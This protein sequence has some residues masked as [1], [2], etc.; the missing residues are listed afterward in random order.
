MS[1]ALHLAGGVGLFLYGIK[2]MSESLQFVAG[3]R[4]RHLIGTLTRTPLRG[5]F[6]GILVTTLIQSS[7]ATTIMTVSFVNAALMN[8]KQAIGII[9]GANIGTT[10]TA[11]II[12]F[13]IKELALP[14]V[15]L[16][17]GMSIF[18]K[19]KKQRHIGDGIIG[20]ALLFLGMQTM[21]NATAFFANYQEA[22]LNL[23]RQPLQCVLI[24]MLVTMV[25]QSSTATIGLTM[26]MASQ[27][28][29]N[30]DAAVPI[31]MGDN[32]GTTITAVLATIGANRHAKQAAA[33]HVFF[34]VFGVLL[35]LPFL[36]FYKEL[37][38]FTSPD[39]PRQLANAH[40]G[41]NIINTMV[42]LPFA[43]VYAQVIQKIIPAHDTGKTVPLY[44]DKNLIEV[45]PTAAVTAVKDEL[46]HMGDIVLKMSA[47]VRSGY[48][49][50]NVERLAGEFA[51]LESS[52]NEIARGIADYAS[53][54]WQKVV[55]SEVSTVL[56]CYVNAAGDLER[57]GD[58]FENL[59]VLSSKKNFSEKAVAEVCDMYDNVEKALVYSLDSIRREDVKKAGVVIDELETQIDAQEKQF[60]RNH[61][62]RL[63]AGECNPEKGI[64]FIDVL[65]NLER[66]GDHCHNIAYFTRDIV[67]LSRRGKPFAG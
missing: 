54:I 27:G 33:A 3:E 51:E 35:F 15:A 16:G 29:L 37:L 9:M 26:A 24:G 2:L 52:V 8:L 48:N 60:R 25:V 44:L 28:L 17:V 23:G 62:E 19:T 5:V 14:A 36:P 50:N 12:A 32:I 63:N 55:S 1:V 64:I 59:I 49:E 65:I 18:G 10:V 38:A 53:E 41:F 30:L 45:S 39:I 42:F 20:F 67:A 21:E 43:S 47:L 61:I 56:S 22:F 34:N 57:V 11:Q 66:I 7:S 40:T 46:L 13:K 58:H 31:I 4:M 6:V